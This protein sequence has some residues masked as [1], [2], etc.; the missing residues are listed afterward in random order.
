MFNRAEIKSI[1]VPNNS[2]KS[3]DE[4]LELALTIV[5]AASE[6]K[7]DNIVLLKV[8]DVSYLA[9]YFAIVT[10]YSNVQVR[11][12]SQAIANKVELE[13][14]RY[15]LRIEGQTEGSWILID[16][17]ETIVHIFKPQERE[18]YNLEAFWGHAEQIDVSQF[19]S[20]IN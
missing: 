9:D 7:G 18:F 1:S 17:G 19:T 12:I 20:E 2:E 4:T 16:Y 14:E 6:R 8:S 15:P 11:A 3:S 13:W 5:E 10:G